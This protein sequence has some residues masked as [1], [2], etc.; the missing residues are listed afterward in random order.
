MSGPVCTGHIP[1]QAILTSYPLSDTTYMNGH[2]PFHTLQIS[3][4]IFSFRHYDI[5]QWGHSLSDTT[6]ISGHIP[7]Q[8]PL[9]SVHMFPFKHC[10]YYRY[11]PS[12]KL[13]I[14][15]QISFQIPIIGHVNF[16]TLRTDI[17]SNCCPSNTTDITWHVPS[18]RFDI[19]N[20]Y[21]LWHCWY[22]WACYLLEF[23][24]DI[25]SQAFLLML[26][27]SPLDM[28]MVPSF[29]PMQYRA[30]PRGATPQLL[31]RLLIDGTGDHR[32]I[33]G[34]KRSTLAW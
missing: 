22:Q 13:D 19:T 16:Q 11:V 8:M 10:W 20:K 9:I 7:F 6:G 17:C 23:M 33:R 4:G 26:N 28:H 29:P 5:Y 32:P 24:A 18:Q 31:R 3:V 21:P 15:G 34:S 30:P 2:I 25:G 1:F 27:L 14:T 12:Q